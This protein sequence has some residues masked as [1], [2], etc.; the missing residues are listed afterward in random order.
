MKL[1]CYHL[2]NHY[3]NIFADY[4]ISKDPALSVFNGKLFEGKINKFKEQ[5]KYFEEL[6]KAELFANLAS[7]IPSFTIEAANS[8]EI[9]ILQRAIRSSGRGNVYPEII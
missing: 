6:T 8:S 2:K 3:L 9:G 7:K 5:S 1:Y 4:I